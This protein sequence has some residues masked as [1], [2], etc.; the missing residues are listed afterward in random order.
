MQQRLSRG[1][2]SFRRDAF[3][4]APGTSEAI[5]VRLALDCSRPF[6]DALDSKVTFALDARY[7]RNVHM[8]GLSGLK[9]AD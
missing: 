2:R 3:R 4:P 1:P 5:A 9:Q 7:L 6:C 8:S